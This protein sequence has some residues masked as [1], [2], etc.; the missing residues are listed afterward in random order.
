M[1][2]ERS[3]HAHGK[4]ELKSRPAVQRALRDERRRLGAALLRLRARTAGR[5][6][7]RPS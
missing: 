6:I 2:A 7:A 4:S 1:V 5:K 3:I